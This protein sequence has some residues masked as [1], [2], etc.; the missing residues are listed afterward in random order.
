MRAC[1]YRTHPSPY[2]SYRQHIERG[3]DRHGRAIFI[4][5]GPLAIMVKHPDVMVIVGATLTPLKTFVL[6]LMNFANRIG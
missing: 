2:I 1:K 5:N 3:A 4:E 6:V